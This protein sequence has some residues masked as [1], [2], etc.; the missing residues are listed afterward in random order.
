MAAAS[1]SA[2]EAGASGASFVELP[3]S[4]V[5]WITEDPQLAQPAF[6]VSADSDVAF[7]DG[8][9][10]E[11]VRFYSYGNYLAFVRRIELRIFLATDPD[12]VEPL[13][14]VAIPLRSVAQTEWDGALPDGVRLRPGDE[15]LYVA[16]LIASDGSFDETVPRGLQMIRP[17]D[18]ERRRRQ[19]LDEASGGLV[20]LPVRELESRRQID[21]TFGRSDLRIQNIVIRGSRV[22]ILGQGMPQGEAVSINGD[23]APVDVEG[24]FVAEYF[25]PAGEHRFD[26]EV[27]QG[28]QA[29]RAELSALVSGTYFFMTALAD[30][31]LSGSSISGSSVPA[32]LDEDYD[33][34]LGEGRLAL[35][36]KSKLQ[37]RYLVTAQADTREREL[38][39]LFDGFLEPDARDVFRRLDADR[40]YPVYGDDSGVHRDVDT[41]GR[42]YLRVDWDKSEALWGN[43]ATGFD[44]GEFGQYQRSLYGAAIDL[45]SSGATTLGES[46]RSF[47][48]FGSEAQTA[49]G[50]S[51]FIGTGGSLYYLRDRDLLPGSE[52]VT[53]EILD[54]TTGRVD[55]RKVLQRDVDYEIDEFQGRLLLTRPLSQLVRENAPGIIRDAPLDGLETRLSADYEYVPTSFSA[56]DV[57]AGAQGRA[58]LT[59]HLA[60]GGTVVDENRRGEDYQLG[61]VDLTLRAGRGTYLRL[62]AASSESTV[63]P[64]FFSDD[65]GLTFV[66][67]N[68]AVEAARDGD[69]KSAEARVNL[70]E[71]GWTS[72]DWTAGAWWRE[73]DSGFSVA[74][75]DTG[76]PV[77][78]TG[79]EFAG[80]L[81]KALRLSGRYTEADR[82][83]SGVDQGQLLLDWSLPSD[84]RLTGELRRVTET[85]SGA[86]ASGAL[87]AAGYSRRFAGHL[88]LYGIAQ[89]TVD[90]DDGRYPAN[91]LYTA[92]LR[93]LYGDLSSVGVEVSSG[94]RGGAASIHAEHRLTP[95]HALYG[96]YVYSTDGVGPEPVLGERTPGGVTLGQRWRITDKVN[97]YNESQ[98]LRAGADRGVTH[99][100]GM[101]FRPAPSVV[102]GFAAQ[103][104]EIEGATG[105]TERRAFSMSAGYTTQA[106]SWGSKFEFRRDS[107]ASERRQR[108]ST[109][110]LSHRLTDDWRIAARFNYADTDDQLDPLGDA[111]FVESNLG[112]AYRPA[113]N[114]RWNALGRYT[115]LYDVGSSGQS[116]GAGYDQRS[117]VVSLEATCRLA[118]RWEIAGKLARRV[119]EARLTR[120]TGPWFDSTANVGAVQL[121]YETVYRWD[122]LAEFRSL[123]TSVDGGS[124]RGWLVGVDRHVGE[125]FRV[126]VG[127]NFTGF[128]DDLTVIDL[129]QEGWFINVT[130]SL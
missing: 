61:Q 96:G 55:S 82:G 79:V 26:V 102:L 97:L 112:F 4:G 108:V 32:G 14:T 22:R 77:R 89:L 128:S 64:V 5:V 127:Y 53:L 109:N 130:G 39:E 31:T 113:H 8:R 99:A 30:L 111:R 18:V 10:V 93:Y 28:T 58:W 24:R 106:T 71:L 67:R 44:A 16:R 45:R 114:D 27:G 94:D 78:E 119:G 110:R 2:D 3:G 17:E 15:L 9:I 29:R 101:D 66:R 20:G 123:R 43:F 63:A 46:L 23:P 7:A 41:Q 73:S 38:G 47:R 91:D 80:T 87:A 85:R 25:L 121:R 126:G 100:L 83:P 70:Q 49:L 35:Y 21:R 56:E 122:A 62:D 36:L 105:T 72:A 86:E 40:Y 124:R 103:K 76:L 34:F 68:P 84:S 120:T 54:P 95:D 81:G 12:L 13:A 51:E 74:R 69:A 33:D 42:M 19:M 60:V 118:Q 1:A 104:G 6:S 117:Q 90:D 116:E 75:A 65:G 37:G 59:D 50:H 98:S 92:G 52:R 48:A 107:G 88:D 57:T 125:H 11:P 115:T 129:D